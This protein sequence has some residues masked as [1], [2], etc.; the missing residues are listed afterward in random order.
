MKFRVPGRP[1]VSPSTASEPEPRA[2]ELRDLLASLAPWRKPLLSLTALLL[3]A[4]AF[5]AGGLWM[6]LPALD[7]AVRGDAS[8]LA[9]IVP[10]AIPFPALL[11]LVLGMI[12]AIAALR[13]TVMILSR[14]AIARFQWGAMASGMKALL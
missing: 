4:A 11:S 1:Q 8:R 14:R 7:L 9:A 10:F 2:P 13:A 6:I 5:E 3:L 12:A